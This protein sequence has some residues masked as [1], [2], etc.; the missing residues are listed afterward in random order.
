MS[1]QTDRNLARHHQWSVADIADVLEAGF[2]SAEAELRREQAVQGLD[3]R[4]EVELHPLLQEILEAASIGATR[5]VR[6][7][8]ESRRR[9]QTEGR[10]CDLVLTPDGNPLVEPQQKQTLFAP[11]HAV[12]LE[13]AFWLEVKCVAQ[14]TSEGPNSSYSSDLLSTVRKDVFKLAADQSIL[15]AGLLIML[16]VASEDVAEHDLRIWQERCLEQTLP[17]AAPA[18]R[19]VPITDRLGN[20]CCCLSLYPVRHL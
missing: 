15:H 14:F 13:D 17:I 1:T 8:S 16:F 11:N 20:Q 18:S 7:P 4:S 6:Y 2:L 3:A 5:E 12:E 10:R 9:R 19:V